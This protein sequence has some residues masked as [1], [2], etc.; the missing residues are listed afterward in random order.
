MQAR[1]APGIF[2]WWG[3]DPEAM[4]NLCLILKIVIKII[5]QM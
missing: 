4:H 1:H 5:E 3:V 2:H